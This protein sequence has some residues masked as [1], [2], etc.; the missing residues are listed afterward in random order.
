MLPRYND[1]A[2][3]QFEEPI[4]SYLP[5]AKSQRWGGLVACPWPALGGSGPHGNSANIHAGVVSNA[6][7]AIRSRDPASPVGNSQPNARRFRS[8]TDCERRFRTGVLPKP[9]A[10]ETTSRLN[11]E[12]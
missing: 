3:R 12:S 2:D 4:E 9:L 11:F 7:H 1:G 8:A 10:K 6:F 5:G